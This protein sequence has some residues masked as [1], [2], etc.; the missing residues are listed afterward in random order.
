MKK[1]FFFIRA[2]VSLLLLIAGIKLDAQNDLAAGPG[3]KVE[4]APPTSE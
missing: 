1:R 3:K 2:G 4:A